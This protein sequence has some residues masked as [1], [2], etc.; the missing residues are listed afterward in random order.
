MDLHLKGKVVI[1]TGGAGLKGSIGETI[2]RT[3]ASEGGIPAFIDI[4]RRGEALA[5]ELQKNGDNC[6]FVK[7][8]LTDEKACEKAVDEIKSRY[9]HIDALVNNLGVNDGV[10]LDKNSEDFIESLKLNLV[11][12]FVMTKYC[13]EELKKSKGSIVNIASKV[14]LTGQGGT[15]GYAAAK[16]GVLALTRE[17]AVDLRSYGIRVNAIVISESWTPGYKEWIEKFDNPDEKLKRI[18]EKIPLGQRMTKPGEIADMVLFLISD[19]ASHI[20]GQ[21]VFVDGGYVHLDRSIS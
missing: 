14:A 15:S 7:A 10:G 2:V 12:F 11:H 3:V 4:N 17:W 9:G 20:T 5:G 19:R 1:I 21:H 13:L 6:M 8:D 18:T 16:G